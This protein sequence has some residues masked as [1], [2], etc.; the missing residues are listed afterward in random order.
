MPLH[1]M[2]Q[3]LR[4]ASERGLLHAWGVKFE[5]MLGPLFLLLSCG[6]NT[7]S[8]GTDV[9][10]SGTRWIGGSSGDAKMRPGDDCIACHRRED[11]PRF[12]V[13]GTVYSDLRQKTHCFGESGVTVRIEDATGQ[14]M[15]LQT[16]AAGNFYTKNK[17][18]P[19]LRASVIRDGVET[20]MIAAQPTGACNS[21]HTSEGANSALG[22]IVPGS[23]LVLP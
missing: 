15:N 9:C 20:P 23:E 3:T 18:E 6:A 1:E 12:T 22:R 7:E 16:N 2:T 5:A 10:V 13:A 21:C 8:V 14:T 11:G 19:P 4:I 17:L